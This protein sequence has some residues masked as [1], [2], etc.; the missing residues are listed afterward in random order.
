MTERYVVYNM[1]GELGSITEVPAQ[2]Y[3]GDIYYADQKQNVYCSC[4]GQLRFVVPH[5][6]DKGRR[7]FEQTGM[8]C[9]EGECAVIPIDAAAEE[10]ENIILLIRKRSYD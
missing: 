4:G 5:G 6:T 8:V 10:V 9:N 2:L 7:V 1:G 3:R